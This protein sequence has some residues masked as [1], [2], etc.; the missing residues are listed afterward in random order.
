MHLVWKFEREL[1]MIDEFSLPVSLQE[2]DVEPEYDM[3]ELVNGGL[4]DGEALSLSAHAVY[5]TLCRVPG[6]SECWAVL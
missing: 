5:S 4:L 2:L 6:V 3:E 1:K